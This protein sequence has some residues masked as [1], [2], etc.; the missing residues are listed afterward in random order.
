PGRRPSSR[1][2]CS[3]SSASRTRT[4]PSAGEVRAQRSAGEVNRLSSTPEA[5]EATGDEVA[6]PAVDEVRE[7]LLAAL[8]AELGDAVVGSEIR[9]RD[10]FVRVR[11]DAWRRAARVCRDRLACDYFC[12]LSGIDWMPAG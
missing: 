7:G 1:A 11:A 6:A 4:W 2:S 12:F 3:S 5:P 8:T 9:D 10:L